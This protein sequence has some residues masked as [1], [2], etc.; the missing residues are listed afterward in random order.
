MFIRVT[1]IDDYGREKPILL[2]AD[3]IVSLAEDRNLEIS[4]ILLT[5][6]VDQIVKETASEIEAL[7]KRGGYYLNETEQN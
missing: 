6:G 1:A 2:N 4:M 5:D 7:L 3:Y